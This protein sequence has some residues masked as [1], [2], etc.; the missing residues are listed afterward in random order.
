MKLARDKL[1]VARDLIDAG[2]YNDAV[3]KAYYA[4]F[5][6]GKSLLLVLGEDP[7]KHEGVVSLFGERIAK[8]GL[9][10]PKY[11]RTLRLMKRLREKSDYDEETWMTKEQAEDA[12]GDAQDFVR[13]AQGILKK[14]LREQHV[15]KR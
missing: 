9:A 3:S 13:T 2:H 1:T 14:L 11:G 12:L 6:A 5:Y 15:R 10:D 4:M 7:V 8:V